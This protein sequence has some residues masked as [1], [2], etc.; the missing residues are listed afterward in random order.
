MINMGLTSVAEVYRY[1]KQFH[2]NPGFG[3]DAFTEL[4][5]SDPDKIRL[6][7]KDWSVKLKID[8]TTKKFPADTDIWFRTW[9]TNPLACRQLLM[10]ETFPEIQEEGGEIYFRIYDGTDDY[11]WDGGA[12]AVAGAGEWNTE[13]EINANI[14][15]FPILPNRTF[16]ITINLRSVDSRNEI[17]P[18]IK[19]IRVLMEVHIDFLEDIVFRSLMPFIESEITAV[20]NFAAIPA[21]PADVASI[22]LSQYRINTPYNITDVE[23]VYDLTADIELLNNLFDSYD[24]GTGIITLNAMLPA[25][26]RPLV[27][28]RYSPEVAYIT[29]QDYVE[30]HKL[31]ALILQ[32]L[33]VPVAQAY[34]RVAREGIVDKSTGAAV[35]VED[36]FR[37]S[38]E[39]RLHGLTAS[40]VDQLR[41]ISKVIDFFERNVFLRSTGLDE[42]YRMY[43]EKEFRDLTTP[44]RADERVFWTRFS[45][46]NIRLPLV[47]TD[48]TAVTKVKM[49]F[50][51]PV[52]AHEDP[53]KGG[54]RIVVNLHTDGGPVQWTR[55]FETE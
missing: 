49:V 25:G 23:R 1:I 50:K 48:A 28:F 6:D 2:F 45:I 10:L 44:G 39:F 14:D 21:F 31:P 11:W 16:A 17:T 26:N 35:V 9:T 36:P 29:H 22:D 13:G 51:E 30:V 43:L 52:G 19:E 7:P 42:F 4:T 47:S 18:R 15:T 55:T 24:S 32:K 33:D 46:Q 3:H 8:Q 12:W 38:I 5:F 20:G 54:S 34:G 53:V 27:V 40:A 37:V 41:L